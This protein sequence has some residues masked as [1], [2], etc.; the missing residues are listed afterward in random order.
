MFLVPRLPFRASF[1]FAILLALT[2]LAPASVA[3]RR[4]AP[5]LDLPAMA[6]RTTDFMEVGHDGFGQ[7]YGHLTDRSRSARQFLESGGP[8]GGNGDEHVIGDA[9]ADRTYI[10][11]LAR[12]HGDDQSGSFSQ[13]AF[14]IVLE[15]EDD[16]EAADAL[17]EMEDQWLEAGHLDKVRRA[18][19]IGDGSFYLEGD[20]I[21]HDVQRPVERTTLGFQVDNIVAA[22]ILINFSDDDPPKQDVTEDLAS[23]QADRIES[24]LDGDEGGALFDKV[25]RLRVDGNNAWM[26]S[27]F[28]IDGVWQCDDV[29]FTSPGACDDA[30]ELADERQIEHSYF[31]KTRIFGN[32]YAD[33]TPESWYWLF[34]DEFSSE[35]AAEAGF[36][37]LRSAYGEVSSVIDLDLGHES[38]SA[39]YESGN[40]NLMFNVVIRVD[41]MV[42]YMI[43]DTGTA[44][45]AEQGWTLE[46]SESATLELAEIQAAC[47]E[48]TESCEA[49]VRIPEEML[50]AEAG[51]VTPFGGEASIAMHPIRRAA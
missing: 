36:E 29:D 42:V 41:N 6:L 28:A 35:E 46:P 12:F 47:M 4:G 3:A 33:G 24:V 43:H 40:G 26:D 17:D 21:P 34:L 20:A 31:L 8:D 18:Q 5:R 2:S 30:Q 44:L 48:G 1:A 11:E 10:L 38:F 16:D 19:Q 25:V 37:R 27:Y 15:F 9:R 14:S 45:A 23:I 13:V 39:H 50:P 49:P 22:I 7:N 51:Y 32:Y